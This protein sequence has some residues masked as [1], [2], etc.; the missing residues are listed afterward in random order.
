MNYNNFQIK[1]REKEND[2][3]FLIKGAFDEVISIIRQFK[4]TGWL[5]ILQV[6]A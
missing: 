6:V 4:E 5:M 3:I 2:N 1:K